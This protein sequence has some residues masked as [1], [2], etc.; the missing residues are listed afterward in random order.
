MLPVEK[1]RGL[2]GAGTIMHNCHESFGHACG[3]SMLDDVAAIN[4]SGGALLNKRFRAF[5]DLLIR[6][7]ASAS[8]QHRNISGDLNDRVI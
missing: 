3:V 5:E 6:R 2:D 4:N 8:H 1:C 7:F